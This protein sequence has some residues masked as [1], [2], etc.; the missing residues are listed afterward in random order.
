MTVAELIER[1]QQEKPYL[2]VRLW[3]ARR[4]HFTERFHLQPATFESELLLTPAEGPARQMPPAHWP[5]LFDEP[6]P[7]ARPGK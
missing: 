6:P 4:E 3:D 2:V 1:L 5:G 7:D